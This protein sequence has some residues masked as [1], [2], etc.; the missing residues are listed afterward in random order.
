MTDVLIIGAAVLTLSL[1]A[2]LSVMG[3]RCR[4]CPG[5][6][7]GVERVRK[8]FISRIRNLRPACAIPDSGGRGVQELLD[9]EM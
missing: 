1:M 5:G 2:S 4:K 3:F 7:V 8:L 9:C 6:V